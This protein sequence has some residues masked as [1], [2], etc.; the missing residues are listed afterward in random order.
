MLASR[1]PNSSNA[2]AFTVHVTEAAAYPGRGAGLG[3]ALWML[4]FWIEHIRAGQFKLCLSA[5]GSQVLERQPGRDFC[6]QSSAGT[7]LSFCTRI[8]FSLTGDKQHLSELQ[9]SKFSQSV[10][11][12]HFE[13]SLPIL[14]SEEII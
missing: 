13:T 5:L 8:R 1:S 2:T 6:L 12:A 11:L 10:S 4:Q 9:V 3:S 7:C 14:F